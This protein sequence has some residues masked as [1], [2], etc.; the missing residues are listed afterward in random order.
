MLC[1][2]IVPEGLSIVFTFE[3]VQVMRFEIVQNSNLEQCLVFN[4]KLVFNLNWFGDS[5]T[6][7]G[8]YFRIGASC[9]SQT[10]PHRLVPFLLQHT[11]VNGHYSY[12]TKTLIT[13]SDVIIIANGRH[14]Y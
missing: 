11:N 13:L 10:A 8:I 1:I 6:R 3:P 2:V 14:S 12:R 4:Q 5:K 9:Y 7:Y